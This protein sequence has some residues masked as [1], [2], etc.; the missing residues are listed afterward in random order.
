MSRT[1]VLAADVLAAGAAAPLGRLQGQV[2][3][4]AGATGPVGCAVVHALAAEGARV[5][6]HWRSDEAA[7]QHLLA[8]VQGDLLA[9]AA[10]LDD[11][12]ALD[13]AAGAVEEHLGAVTLLVNAAHPRQD[14][15]TA[16]ADT[17]A[18]DLLAQLTGA[19][20]HAA[21][22]RRF[23]PGM[24]RAGTGRIVYIA[25]ALMARPAAGN[26][27]YGAAKAAA[28]VLTR[29]TAL[30][31]GRH[32][33]TANV[34]APGRIVDPAGEEELSPERAA[35]AARLLERMALPTF[36]SP[37]HVADAVLGLLAAPYVTGQTLWVTGGEPIA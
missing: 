31:E 19:A 30:E 8:S 4:V 14:V 13:A 23:V 6:V 24:R 2:A 10:D 16:V 18:G 28:S 5:G 26:G 36:P 35:L 32:G 22:L 11:E 33:I 17:A 21:L 9:V 34:V 1:D 12:R 20:G 15:H 3:F 29:Y 37:Q 7:A 25:G 27:A